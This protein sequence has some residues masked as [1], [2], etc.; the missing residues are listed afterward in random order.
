V[1]G[2]AELR[3]AL[4]LISNGHFSR[5]DPNVFRPVVD[6]LINADPFLVLADYAAYIACQEQVS[7]AWQDEENWTRMSILNTAR[8]GKFSSD[9]A[10]KEYCEE[11]WD[12]QTVTM[13]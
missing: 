13:K 3:A 12:V 9:R 4:E 6:N 2:N 1:A 8:S 11:I 5:G 10:I 7:A